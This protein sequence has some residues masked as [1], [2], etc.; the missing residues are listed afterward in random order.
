MAFGLFG[1]KLG[2]QI[3][4]LRTF[5]AAI[6]SAGATSDYKKVRAEFNLRALTLLS[7]TG[8][9]EVSEDKWVTKGWSSLPSKNQTIEILKIVNDFVTNVDPIIN[10]IPVNDDD[11]KIIDPSPNKV[12]TDSDKIDNNRFK[13]MMIAAFNKSLTYNDFLVIAGLAEKV[14]RQTYRLGCYWAAG[15]TLAIAAGIGVYVYKKNKNEEKDEEEETAEYDDV[16]SDVVIT[17]DDDTP[18]VIIGDESDVI[19]FID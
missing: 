19:T 17:V 14:R 16:G 3:E 7:G 1:N 15:I 8:F 5:V 11:M 10:N 9:E 6:K 13:E 12:N 4:E 2:K 18:I